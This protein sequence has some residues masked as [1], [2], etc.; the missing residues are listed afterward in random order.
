M[1][2]IILTFLVIGFLLPPTFVLAAENVVPEFNPLCW[3]EDE[4]NKARGALKGQTVKK[5]D[6]G[7]VQEK[8][9]E[10]DKAGWGKCLPTGKTTTMI[11]FGGK[12]QFTDVGDFL[13]TNYNL[14]LSIISIVA[15]IM[16]IIAGIQWVSSGGNSE[17]I[18]SAKKR[19]SGAV[20][21]MFIAFFSYIILNTINPALVNLRLPQVWMIRPYVV[22]PEFCRD[23][24]ESPQFA[25][26]AKN[27]APISADALK[28]PEWK[29]VETKGMDCGD[30]YFSQIGG[31]ATCAGSKCEKPHYSC[32]KSTDGTTSQN[33]MECVE[34]DL[35]VHVHLA[36]FEEASARVM[37]GGY[38]ADLEK[39]ILDT[40]DIYLS[41]VC[42]P[43]ASS[44]GSF[45]TVGGGRC[46][47]TIKTGIVEAWKTS[48]IEAISQSALNAVQLVMPIQSALF[49]WLFI[50]GDKGWFK[51]TGDN[52]IKIIKKNGTDY[53]LQFKNLIPDSKEKIDSWGCGDNELVGFILSLQL[54][55]KFNGFFDA[56][57]YVAP[58]KVDIWR[59][60]GSNGYIPLKLLKEGLSVD[61]PITEKVLK[62]AIEVKDTE[63][64]NQVY[65]Q[66]YN[67]KNPQVIV[68]LG[69]FQSYWCSGQNLKDGC[70]F[71]SPD[72]KY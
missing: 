22:T 41:G 34:A 18:T 6:G 71:Y 28:K 32:M 72:L 21:G 16:I 44:Q 26:A 61:A 10:C 1:R 68:P 69:K 12:T 50:K 37:Y 33:K 65:Y 30:K 3:H 40:S 47:T 39:D 5:G 7:W 8:G 62:D 51:Y 53:T 60:L 11:A 15:V 13:K 17:M 38:L 29:A 36:S 70:C 27:G 25:L 14:A 23:I 58:G 31:T 43:P 35:I 66:A 2:K 45:M 20:I 4:C 19:I 64:V 24:T 57:I 59:G 67:D 63:P 49:D 55:V 46:A 56:N 48:A 9:G 54:K 42:K 52:N